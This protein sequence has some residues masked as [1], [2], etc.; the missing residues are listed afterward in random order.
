METQLTTVERK[1][2]AD[3]AFE[4]QVNATLS[5]HSFVKKA[6]TE[7]RKDLVGFTRRALAGSRNAAENVDAI[8]Y[9]KAAAIEIYHYDN[10]YLPAYFE[11]ARWSR[12]THSSF[13]Q[14]N[15]KTTGF[16]Y[17]VLKNPKRPDELPKLADLVKTMLEA[18]QKVDEKRQEE[19]DDE[20]AKMLIGVKSVLSRFENNEGLRRLVAEAM[21]Q[22]IWDSMLEARTSSAV[23]G[24]AV[25][26][27]YKREHEA[28]PVEAQAA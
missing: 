20:V 17:V 3:Q 6:K 13:K 10:R 1:A 12:G 8:R 19:K 26:E 25:L 14:L 5:G 7:L 2:L 15:G 23:H 11:A 27:A 21:P 22:T 18:W 24:E 28:A 4:D 9:L 16:K